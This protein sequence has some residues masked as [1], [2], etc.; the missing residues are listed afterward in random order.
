LRVGKAAFC[1]RAHCG[2]GVPAATF[3]SRSVLCFST[4]AA[5]LCALKAVFGILWQV[6]Q[7]LLSASGSRSTTLCIQLNLPLPLLVWQALQFS[8][9]P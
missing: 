7:A 4:S 2:V 6:R 1:A 9:A 3:V 5:A 8:I